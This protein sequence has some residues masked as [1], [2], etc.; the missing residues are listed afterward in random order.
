MWADIRSQNGSAILAQACVISVRFEKGFVI[1]HSLY[2][3]HVRIFAA[4]H[5]GRKPRCWWIGWTD[6][7]VLLCLPSCVMCPRSRPW[8][9]R[10]WQWTYHAKKRVELYVCKHC[11]ETGQGCNPPGSDYRKVSLQLI[12]DEPPEALYQLYRASGGS[13]MISCRF[14]LLQHKMSMWTS[15]HSPIPMIVVQLDS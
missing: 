9:Q 1:L 2:L 15:G 4:V 10:H 8:K 11:Q 13:S 6:R 5:C 12:I 3:R 7:K 14:Q